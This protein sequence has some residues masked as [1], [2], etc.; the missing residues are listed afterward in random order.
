MD[1]DD[2]ET[3][4]R[5]ERSGLAPLAFRGQRIAAS[6]GRWA[7]GQEQNRWHNL[8]V[9]RTVGGEY[10]VEIIYRTLWQGES[11]HA[12]VTAIGSNPSA[13]EGAF[14]EIDPCECVGGYPPGA[15]YEDRQ[16]RLLE[17]LR[18][19]YAEQI[20]EILAAIPGTEEHLE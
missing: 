5:L 7:N 11:G 4:Y 13:I 14:R 3:Q 15:Q 8:A 1:R 12:T 6:E 20:S 2:T 9:Y 16:R 17:S 10:V 18:R 19:R